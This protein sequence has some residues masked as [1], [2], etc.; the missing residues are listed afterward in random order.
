MPDIAV[1]TKFGAQVY[2]RTKPDIDL[3]IY[4][5]GLLGPDP[6]LF[7]RWYIPPFRNR[8]NR[9]SSIMHRERTGDF[10]ASLAARAVESRYT[11]SY[12]C[13][14]LCHYALDSATHPYINGLAHNS[15]AVHMAIE[16]RLDKMS[17][18]NIRIPPFLPES[19]RR[20]VGGAMTD[21][22]GWDDAW[23]KLKKGRRDMAPFYRIVT[24]KSGK[25]DKLAS[26]TG[27]KLRFVSYKSKA[28][29]G[30]DLSGFQP[31]YEK[32]LDDAVRFIKAA[33]DF[34]NGDISESGFRNI[35]GDRSYIDG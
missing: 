5:F 34:V 22:Y 18:E 32:A 8:V 2:E 10:L 15:S 7:Y 30:M 17:G 31:L 11:F 33:S 25:L 12:L 3:D 23:E 4:N 35:I 29:D 14:F 27:T 24:D 1:H 19:L 6:F 13:G 26:K 16:H 21:I 28:V 20:S 9:Y